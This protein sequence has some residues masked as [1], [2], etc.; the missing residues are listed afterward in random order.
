M[1]Y[2]DNDFGVVIQMLKNYEHFKFVKLICFHVLINFSFIFCAA[3]LII[4]GYNKFFALTLYI[5]LR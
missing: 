2:D 1:K 4:M 5:E 3:F